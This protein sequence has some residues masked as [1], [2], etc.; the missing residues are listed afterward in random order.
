MMPE[1]FEDAGPVVGLVTVF[2]YA[3]GALLTAVA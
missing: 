3:L 1:A 2:G